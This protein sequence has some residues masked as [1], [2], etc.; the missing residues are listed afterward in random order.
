MP[1]DEIVFMLELGPNHAVDLSSDYALIGDLTNID[2]FI[3]DANAT[4]TANAVALGAV[5]MLTTY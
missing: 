3:W 4:M 1:L 2:I 5:S